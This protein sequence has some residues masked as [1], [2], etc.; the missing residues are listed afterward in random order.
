MIDAAPHEL[1]LSRHRR[2]FVSRA[3]YHSGGLGQHLSRLIEIARQEGVLSGYIAGKIKPGDEAIGRIVRER[4]GDLIGRWTPVRFM[5]GV[6][7]HL[8]N[9]LFD[10]RASQHLAGKIGCVVGMNGQALRCFRRAQ[11]LGCQ[12]L[13]LIAATSHVNNVRRQ[14]DIA[15]AEFPIEADW[16]SEGQRQKTLQE[17][18]DADILFV[19][20]EYSRQSFL[21]EGVP[22]TKLARVYYPPDKRFTT[23]QNAPEDRIF[24]VVYCGALT[25]TKGVPLLV[26]A[27]GRLGDKDAELCLVGSCAT[28]KMRIWLECA[29]ERDP[30]IHWT[31]GDPL[32]IYQRATVYAHP[33]YQDGAAYSVVEAMACG[34]P[35]ILS[36]DTG[37]KELVS[38]GVNGYVIGT[39]DEEALFDRLQHLL[40]N[41][42]RIPRSASS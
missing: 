39:G 42:L 33:S 1:S 6:R 28:R 8:E 32:P 22:E 40:R 9:D 29:I 7:A 27:F 3:G 5:P 38:E 30:R 15:N 34:L 26:S 24:R 35:V 14:H 18:L 2:V 16:L 23:P 25:V 4:W 19:G 41:P 21:A 11:D 36:E 12:R 13:E 17:Y 37:N 20:S 10:R 31:S